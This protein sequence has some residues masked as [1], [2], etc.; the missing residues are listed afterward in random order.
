MSY[1]LTDEE[2][3]AL[4]RRFEE[5]D[6]DTAATYGPEDDLPADLAL[7][8]AQAAHDL[9]EH[10]A[11]KVMSDAVKSARSQGYSWHKIGLSLGITGEAARQRY[12][13]KV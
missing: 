7:V 13:S 11:E 6:P 4:E 12:M 2:A 8:R 1:M 5:F 10:R 3:V 9:F